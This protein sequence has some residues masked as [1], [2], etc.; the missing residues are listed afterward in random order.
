MT[1]DYSNLWY[2][3]HSKKLYGTKLEKDLKQILESL[4]YPILCPNKDIG[5]LG[6]IQPYLEIIDQCAGLIVHEYQNFVGKGCFME[7]QHAL[8]NNKLVFVLR[9]TTLV[10]VHSVHLIDPTDWTFK[11]GQIHTAETASMR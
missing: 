9:G 2:F 3:A 6:G 8:I 11:Y 5:E 7:V 1:K 4:N 10:P